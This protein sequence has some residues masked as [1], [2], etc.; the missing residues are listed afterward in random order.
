M[1]KD[2]RELD[3][4]RTAAS[5]D[6]ALDR[7]HKEAEKW[8][9]GSPGSIERRLS[10]CDRLLHSVR[11]TV[12]RLS[13]T[14]SHRYL[15]A[16]EELQSD[17]RALQALLEDVYTG[18]SDRED[19]SGLPGRRTAKVADSTP[20]SRLNGT[21]QRWVTLESAKFVAAHP[22]ALDDTSELATRATHHAQVQTSTF[23]PA[24]SAAVTRAFVAAVVDLGR[25][26]Y[27]PTSVRTA[28]TLDVSFAPEAMYL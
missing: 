13:T 1:F 17:R 8:F 6:A 22:D 21:D 3:R 12:A 2:A 26:A 24:R 5:F 28:A 23:S 7:Y 11:A 19:G 16:A 4:Q 27:V 9:D 18:A 20:A 14:A 15:S 10:F 25:Q